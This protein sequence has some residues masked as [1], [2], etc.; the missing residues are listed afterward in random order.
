MM[1]YNQVQ[2]YDPMLTLIQNNNIQ[3]NSSKTI[4]KNEH[5]NQNQQSQV[6]RG[7][8]PKENSFNT[9]NTHTNEKQTRDRD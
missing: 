1:Q 2:N 7:R 4:V 6:K 3:D 9:E 5:N 8:P